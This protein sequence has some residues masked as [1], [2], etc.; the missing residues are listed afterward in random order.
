LVDSSAL[1]DLHQVLREGRISRIQ[2]RHM[3]QLEE[4]SFCAR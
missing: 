4:F 3:P 1:Q 2:D